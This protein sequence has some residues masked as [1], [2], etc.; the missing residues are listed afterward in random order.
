M[1]VPFCSQ[2]DRNLAFPTPL[3]TILNVINTQ[4]WT[5]LQSSAGSPVLFFFFYETYRMDDIHTHSILSKAFSDFDQ[6]LK[7]KHIN[8]SFS[9]YTIFTFVTCW[10]FQAAWRVVSPAHSCPFIKISGNAN[11]QEWGCP[12]NNVGFFCIYFLEKKPFINFGISA[13]IIT[14]YL[15][16]TARL[17]WTYHC[18]LIWWW[19]SLGLGQYSKLRL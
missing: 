16:H 14:N 9:S 6:T 15:L 7:D 13:P 11:D 4:E 18:V 10:R 3:F 2:W 17:L 19:S 5:D 8:N 1:W 12:S